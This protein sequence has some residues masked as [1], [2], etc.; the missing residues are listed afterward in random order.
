MLIALSECMAALLRVLG[1]RVRHFLF[2]SPKADKSVLFSR[3]GS[4]RVE[5]DSTVATKLQVNFQ[6]ITNNV[7]I[8]SIKVGHWILVTPQLGSK[9]PI[10]SICSPKRGLFF[11]SAPSG[12][13][14]SATVTP[15]CDEC[16]K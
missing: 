7:C 1:F 2:T 13:P 10:L 8:E 12:T 16:I 4:K 3:L 15:S 9:D 14:S 6:N 11:L 5:S